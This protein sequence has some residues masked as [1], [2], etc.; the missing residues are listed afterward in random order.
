MGA[1]NRGIYSRVA[2]GEA[3]K[4]LQDDG[5][6]AER[7]INPTGLY[8]IVA[9]NRDRIVLVAVR[10]SRILK[11]SSFHDHIT[12]LTRIIRDNPDHIKDVEFWIYRSPGWAK[13]RVTQ[14]GAISIGMVAA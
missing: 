12:K 6:I 1:S 7:V 11:L 4:S 8:D 9:W 2:V 10:S 13:W 14:G 3:R 5:Y